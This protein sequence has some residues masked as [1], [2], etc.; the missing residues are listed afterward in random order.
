MDK[1]QK[2]LADRVRAGRKVK[3]YTQKQ[4]ADVAGVSLGVVN[5]FER[6]KNYPQPSNL[7]ALLRAVGLDTEVAD[8]KNGNGP[9]A[10][11]G[12][13]ER[14]EECPTC[15]RI[16]WP[17]DYELTFDI[18]GAHMDTLSPADRIAFQ[19]YVTRPALKR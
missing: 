8:N 3:H 4:L 9:T 6:Y 1:S 7:Q 18:L 12:D 17:S 2:V 14:L 11:E 5:N 16:V 13:D 15:R 19:R 10:D